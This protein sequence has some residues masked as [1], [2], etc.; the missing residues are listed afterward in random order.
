[1]HTPTLDYNDRGTSLISVE[2]QIETIKENLIGLK[3]FEDFTPFSLR[4]VNLSGAW[5]QSGKTLT[6]YTRV[7]GTV[8]FEVFKFNGG[9]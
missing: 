1:M 3:I 6:T 7:P 9:S 5:I 8:F 4:G 2:N